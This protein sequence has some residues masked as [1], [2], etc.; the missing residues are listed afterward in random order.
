MASKEKPPTWSGFFGGCLLL[1]LLAASG[2]TT[3]LWLS[4]SSD[5]ERE[6]LKLVLFDPYW[7]AIKAGQFEQATEYWTDAWKEKKTAQQLSE[8]YKAALKEHG[9]LKEQRIHVANGQV[10]PGQIGEMKRVETL[11]EF[12][13]GWITKVTYAITRPSSEA[14]WKI[15]LSTVE[16]GVS[17]GEGP[18]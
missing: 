15:D 6:N 5:N 7:K 1:F 14:S 11:F 2:L 12:E 13:D 8:T 16:S 10:V 3:F 4:Q 9:Q 18:W 17:L